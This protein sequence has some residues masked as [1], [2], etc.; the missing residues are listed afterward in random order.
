MC[1]PRNSWRLIGLAQGHLLYVLHGNNVGFNTTGGGVCHIPGDSVASALT[2]SLILTS[3]TMTCLLVSPSTPP[4]VMARCHRCRTSQR[5]IYLVLKCADH[6]Q[7]QA[8]APNTYLS[9]TSF[10]PPP[11]FTPPNYALT[12]CF[13]LW[14]TVD[15]HPRGRQGGA[16]A[17][18]ERL[19]V[20]RRLS[21]GQ[22]RRRGG[23]PARKY[24]RGNTYG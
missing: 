24:H 15:K 3:P 22:S 23:A 17:P 6:I 21:R 7:T 14:D 13:T 10:T 9:S 19:P 20:H 2:L 1:N 5:L 18:G 4:V 12:L 16:R 11:R 8:V